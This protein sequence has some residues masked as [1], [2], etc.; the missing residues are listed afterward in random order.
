MQTLQHLK[1]KTKIFMTAI[2]N[3]YSQYFDTVKGK[4]VASFCCKKCRVKR[5]CFFF[6]SYLCKKADCKKN[7]FR[8]ICIK[9]LYGGGMQNFYDCI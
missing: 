1:T 6:A 2:E 9:H 7:L 3:T 8:T 5:Y 4:N